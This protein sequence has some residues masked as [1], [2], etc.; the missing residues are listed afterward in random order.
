MGIY[1]QKLEQDK[2]NAAFAA[3]VNKGI[4]ALKE[5][6][7]DRARLETIKTKEA[8]YRAW[9]SKMYPSASPMLSSLAMTEACDRLLTTI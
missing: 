4:K 7:F 5:E 9:V 8:E 6:G 3:S 2:K 1:S